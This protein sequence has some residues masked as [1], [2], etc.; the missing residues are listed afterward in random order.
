MAEA[1]KQPIQDEPFLRV[2]MVPRAC[3]GAVLITAGFTAPTWGRH[4]PPL[5]GAYLRPWP[6]RHPPAW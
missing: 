1:Y 5:V 3:V 6:R 4:R 2:T